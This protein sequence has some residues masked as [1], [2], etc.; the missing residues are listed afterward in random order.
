VRWLAILGVGEDG[1]EGLSPAARTLISQATLVAGGARHLALVAPLIRGE[2]MRWPRPLTRAIAPIL[3]RRPNPV[4]VLASGNPFC[5]GIGTLLMTI[6]PVTETICIP[7]PSAYALA[8]TRLG[9]SMRETSNITFCGRPLAPLAP[10]LQPGRNIVA[11]S[12][13]ATTPAAVA[14]F[15]TQRGFGPSRIH[16]MEALGGPQENIRT[17]TAA[18]F[19]LEHGHPLNLLGIEVIPGPDAKIIPLAAG[20]PDAMFE[21]DGQLTKQEIRAVT[22]AKLAPRAGECLWDIGAGSGAVGIEWM[23]RHPSNTAFAIESDSTRVQR[24]TRNADNLGVPGLAVVQSRAPEAF[25]PLP[26]PDAIFFGGG[27]HRPGMIEAAWTRLRPGGRMVANGVVIETE[28]AL[29]AA[30]KSFGGTLTRLSVER[31]DTIGT[32]HGFR[33]AMTITQWSA[34][35]PA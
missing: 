17:T 33:P 12:A 9:W 35:K 15:L 7:V 5:D 32:L 6:G 11:L 21:H 3:A 18:G 1:V 30:Q 23:L 28:T 2:Q 10:L 26:T 14:A 31:L 16:L 4:V 19:D 13:D 20:L 25:L 34:Q 22:L 8:Y 27:A 24:I 29:F